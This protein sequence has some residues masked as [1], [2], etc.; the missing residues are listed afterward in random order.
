MARCAALR[1]TVQYT[2]AHGSGKARTA[3]NSFEAATLV[4]AEVDHEGD[5]RW[6]HRQKR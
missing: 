1:T 4:I 3:K 2:V 6:D 5:Q